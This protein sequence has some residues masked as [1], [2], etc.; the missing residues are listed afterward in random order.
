M[1]K[2]KDS[3]RLLALG[4]LFGVGGL[5][6]IAVT[7]SRPASASPSSGAGIGV[8]SYGHLSSFSNLDQYGYVIGKRQQV[9]VHA[10]YPGGSG[11]TAQSE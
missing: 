6:A 1:S 7:P 5:T 9:V 3:V 4:A 10:G 11:D 8:L 2:L